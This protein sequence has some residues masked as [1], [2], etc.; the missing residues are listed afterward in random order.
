MCIR[1]SVPSTRSV[2]PSTTQTSRST[3][4]G[5]P[6][7]PH[8]DGVLGR[9]LL[10][11]LGALA[12]IAL[13]GALPLLGWWRRN[14]PVRQAREPRERDEAVWHRMV[15]NLRDLGY[16]ITTER[17]PQEA[18]GRFADDNPRASTH[19]VEAVERAARSIENS[20]YAPT[21]ARGMAATTERVTRAARSDAFVGA[22]LRAWLLPRSAFGARS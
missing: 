13:L 1:D 16:V 14:R 3:S 18:A 8:D 4:H 17:S 15:W 9:V 5:A 6:V 21:P 12:V 11:L 7:T 22:R 10:T 2:A 19:L 20:R